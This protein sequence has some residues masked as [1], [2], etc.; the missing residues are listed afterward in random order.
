MDADASFGAWIQQRR[1]ALDLTQDELARR[2]G[3]S[4]SAIRK[5]ERDERRPSRQVAELL[6]QHLRIAADQRELFLRVARAELRVDR[7]PPPALDS[8]PAPSNV[9]CPATPLVGREPELAALTRLLNDPQCRLL[10]LVGPGGM[11]K[12][13][14]A[15]EAAARQ[16]AAFPDGAAFVS[17]APLSSSDFLVPA[18]ADVLGFAFQGQIE[19]RLQLLHYLRPKQTLLAL[20]NLEHLL[21]GAALLAEILERAPKVKLLVTSRERLNLQ[22]EWVVEIQGLPVPPAGEVEHLDDYSAAALFIQSARRAQAGFELKAEERPAVARICQ[23]VGGMPLGI[24]LAA[25]W[26]SV[27]PCR[28]IAR[29]IER[30]LDFLATTMRDAP[31]RHR[32]LRAAFE[33][34]WKLLA[35]DERETLS[36]LSIFRGGFAREAA[37]RVAGAT[38]PT[39][40]ALVSKSLV[41]RMDSPGGRYDLHEVVRQCAWSLLADETATRDQH[42]DYYLAVLRDREKALKGAAQLDAV[43]ELT[44]EIDNLRAAWAWAVERE[45]FAPLGQAARCL[46]WFCDMRGW[47]REGIEQGELAAQALRAKA[48]SGERRKALGQVL[49]SQSVLYFRL[50]QYDRA[51]TLFDES[52]ALLRPMGDPALLTDPLLFNGIVMYLSGEIEQAQAFLDE[53]IACARA[54]GDSWSMALGLFNRGYLANLLGR[55]AE[56]YEQMQAA[57]AMWRTLGDPRAIA[58]GLNFLSPVTITLGRYA[59]AHAFLRESLGLSTQVGD[60]WG[61]GTAYRTLG[62]LA[63]AQGNPAEAQSCLRKSL[64][65]FSEL[66]AQWD[67]VRSLTYLGETLTVAGESPGARHVL[68]EAARLAVEAHATPVALEALIGLARLKAQSGEAESAL[69]L[70]AHAAR[71]PA[72][73]YEAKARAEQLRAELEAPLTPQQVEATQARAQAKTFDAVMAEILAEAAQT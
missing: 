13:R 56:A 31:E 70:L 50:G 10:T 5:I 33:H 60:R 67:V 18:I 61:R 11:G 47:L 8:R 66:G 55:H 26:V 22:G 9:P 4:L 17:L 57:L 44:E 34:S 65:L 23:M 29:E 69:A 48:D 45:K 21:G 43:R 62:L 24:E 63:L 64:E 27:L 20:D 46:G 25:A 36:R 72:G 37:E 19:P 40:S 68:L 1:K 30:N 38:L 3:C 32:S 51:R 15:I 58:F 6:A 52:L 41:R 71:H 2:V 42:C 59:E 39:L 12:T 73:T 53:G 7:L 54:A 28:E 16:Q 49:A 14:L 35:P